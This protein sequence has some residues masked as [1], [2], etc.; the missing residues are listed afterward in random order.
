MIVILLSTYLCSL[1]LISAVTEHTYLDGPLI[2]INT[3]C[4][5]LK[6]DYCGKEEKK[7]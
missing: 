1:L 4:S 5:L 6:I 2:R 7:H 3:E